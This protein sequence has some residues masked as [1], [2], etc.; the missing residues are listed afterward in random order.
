MNI[1]PLEEKENLQALAKRSQRVFVR[2]VGAVAE[3]SALID[4][5]TVFVAELPGRLESERV[6]QICTARQIAQPGIIFSYFMIKS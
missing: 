2:N 3:S 4:V 5:G 6:E 1:L